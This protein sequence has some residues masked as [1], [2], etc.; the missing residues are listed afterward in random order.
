[1]S[2]SSVFE[3]KT[4]QI[5]AEEYPHLAENARNHFADSTKAPKKR[6]IQVQNVYP[7]DDQVLRIMDTAG[8]TYFLRENDRVAP[9]NLIV[10]QRDG[11]SGY[12]KWPVWKVCEEKV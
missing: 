4:G 10:I 9:Q 12:Y 11:E 6:A 8:N 2:Q 1:M 3:K 7:W 5:F